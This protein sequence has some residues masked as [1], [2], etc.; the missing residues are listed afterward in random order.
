MVGETGDSVRRARPD[1]REPPRIVAFVAV[2]YV[3]WGLVGLAL[4]P[5]YVVLWARE[6]EGAFDRAM[7]AEGLGA[8][9]G[10]VVFFLW[11][12]IGV[13]NLL[14]GRWLRRLQRRGMWLAAVCATILLAG[15]L[16]D[17]ARAN[18]GFGTVLIQYAFP[19]LSLY[20]VVRHR[21]LFAA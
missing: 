3:L 8:A 7:E 19:L 14:A 16:A 10:G 5:I 11:I 15:G 4:L 12:A 21:R 18:I 2:L 6:G 9:W 13:S 20:A 1:E 17:T